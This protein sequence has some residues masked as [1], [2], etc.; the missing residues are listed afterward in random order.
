ML[1]PIIAPPRVASRNVNPS[2]IILEDHDAGWR[3]L[4]Q[5]L[6]LHHD[7]L[8]GHRK[9]TQQSNMILAVQTRAHILDRTR[10]PKI[11]IKSFDKASLSYRSHMG[12][13]IGTKLKQQDMWT[14]KSDL[15]MY[16]YV[17]ECCFST[18]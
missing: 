11:T 15:E 12:Y 9:F 17:F 16:Y 2:Q 14:Y 4:A 6:T 13:G 7:M 1:N 10:S 3:A 8:T 18:L 5:P